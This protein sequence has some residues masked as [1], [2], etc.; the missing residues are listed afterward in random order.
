MGKLYTTI[1]C[2]AIAFTTIQAQSIKLEWANQN[3]G[4]GN[5]VAQDMVIDDAGNIYIAGYFTD[6]ADFDPGVD[7]FALISAG[8]KD[9]FVQKLTP[10][11]ELVWAKRMGG[12][13][14]DQANAIAIDAAGNVYTTGT[15]TG[16]VDFN[17]GAATNN[18]SSNGSNTDIFIQK[19]NNLGNYVLAL[20]IGNANKEAVNDITVDAT[21]IMFLTGSFIGTVDF[22][23]GSGAANLISS[24]TTFPDVFV[25]KLST[26]GAY[27]WAKKVG[28]TSFDEGYG[29]A[30][31]A[32]GN[33]YTT[34]YFSNE[35]DFDPGAGG[36][37]LNAAP[38]R[39][40]FVHKLTNL[41]IH[42]WAK[43]LDGS[44]LTSQGKA[45]TVDAVGN[46]YL[47]GYFINTVDFDPGADTL[48][49]TSAGGTD[50]FILK[51]DAL[52]DL[53]WA[54]QLAG[55]ASNQGLT[56]CV[57]KAGAV[58]TAGYFSNTVDFDPGIDA[59][60]LT[61]TGTS[62]DI[63][64]QKLDSTGQLVWAKNIGNTGAD[65]AQAIKVD[66][67]GNV[68][69][70]GAFSDTV[71]FDLQ[72]TAFNLPSAGGFDAF[73]AKYSPC[74]V[75]YGNVDTT[76]C[77]AFT[78][79][80][81]VTYT[82]SGTYT[83]MLTNA[84][85]CDSLIVLNVTINDTA[86]ETLTAVACG[87]YTLNTETYD[88][89]GSYTQMLTSAAGCDSILTL[90]L[91][92]KNQPVATVVQLGDTLTATDT[93]AQYQWIDC[94]D[95][96]PIANA[97]RATYIATTT[98]DYAVVVTAN[99][100]T[101]TSACF[102]VVISGIEEQFGATFALYP[103]PSQGTVNIDLGANYQA[104]TVSVSNLAGQ[105]ILQQHYQQTS[106]L[107]FELNAPAGMYLVT[108]NNGQ[109]LKRTLKLA[110]D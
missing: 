88:T 90:E 106:Q 94:S 45:I 99:G 41:G 77:Y 19:L 67:F 48:Y 56:I 72:T 40:I 16:V 31:D 68:I 87:S 36:D 81:G 57:D 65:F 32:T 35:V 18:Q 15:F 69:I 34:G 25:V 5:V 12:A 74:T 11:G 97:T 60:E 71:D 29:I 20:K 104:L 26:A 109:G 93:L 83:E 7:T 46:I 43:Q 21:G 52:G 82:A 14:A 3:S 73:V 4:S 2:W 63:Y 98:G 27:L 55:I 17:P 103:N 86:R 85:G 78:S 44:L 49:L 92:I 100:C 76:T 22:N 101:D 28:G 79:N 53:A 6:T 70:A 107:T 58:Y 50:P 66:T 51:L 89:S 108:I 61:T 75:T 84:D 91:V 95:N 8:D 24:G 23:P 33:V 42:V 62:S 13:N 1:L 64:A 110:K 102:S 39:D 80:T 37:T 30:L 38:S 59:F 10:A 105:T 96:S 54:R 47:T 9:I